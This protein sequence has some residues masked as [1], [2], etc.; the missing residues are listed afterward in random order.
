[1]TQM[2][3]IESVLMEYA[4]PLGKFVLKKRVKIMNESYDAFPPDRLGELVKAVLADAIF[5]PTKRKEAHSVLA[6][7]L[8]T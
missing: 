3:I 6:K 5:D 8:R 1:M 2:K 4:G 7:Q